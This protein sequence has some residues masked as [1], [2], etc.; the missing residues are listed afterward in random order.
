MDSRTPPPTFKGSSTV[1]DRIHLHLYVLDT[2]NKDRLLRPKSPFDVCH[3]LNDPSVREL[4]NSLEPGPKVN[5]PGLRGN[6]QRL[7]PY[8]INTP[9]GPVLLQYFR[10]LIGAQTK[11][12]L[13]LARLESF[14][15]Y[16]KQLH[17]FYIEQRAA[18]EQKYANTPA[19]G[20]YIQESNEHVKVR[21]AGMF[22][23][24]R[25]R[26]QISLDVEFVKLVTIKTSE[27]MWRNSGIM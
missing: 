4:L 27:E 12:L 23:A 6:L 11:W 9:S 1:T 3:L 22:E 5:W 26:L 10:D 20:R 21:K 2:A 8:I 15:A 19:L 25:G 7:K 14:K 24:E 16:D 17:R 18:L 13:V